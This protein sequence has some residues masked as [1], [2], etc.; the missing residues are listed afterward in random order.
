MPSDWWSVFLHVT[1]NCKMAA[2]HA[3]QKPGNASSSH[4]T[5]KQH[6][7]KPGTPNFKPHIK[8]IAFTAFASAAAPSFSTS[9]F[10][11]SRNSKV[12]LALQCFTAATAQRS[13]HL[14]ACC[15]TT[16]HQRGQISTHRKRHVR[17]RRKRVRRSFLFAAPAHVISTFVQQFCVERVLKAILWPKCHVKSTS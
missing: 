13:R 7:W 16:L 8:T 5:T 10:R 3:A 2:P 17:M 12:V 11:T 6:F 9:L 1:G 15:H 14:H 4:W